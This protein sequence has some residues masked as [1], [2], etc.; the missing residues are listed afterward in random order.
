ME[1][2]YSKR[3]SGCRGG[4][5][6][7][8]P[9]RTCVGCRTRRPQ[10]DMVRISIVNG[11]P[12]LSANAREPGRGAYVCL[13]PACVKSAF[14]KERLARA[15]RHKLDAGARDDLARQLAARRQE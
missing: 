13:E 14:D 9:I 2:R 3:L 6:V 7:T 4:Q 11:E 5:E 15:L 8:T 10:R 12:R 1:N